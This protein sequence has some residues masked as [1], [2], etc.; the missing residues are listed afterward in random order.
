[1]RFN[2]E[3]KLCDKV[4]KH[5]PHTTVS[6]VYTLIT[7]EKNSHAEEADHFLHRLSRP[8]GVAERKCKSR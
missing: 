6:R 1:M 7:R 5:I 4:D 3:N 8:V 2:G